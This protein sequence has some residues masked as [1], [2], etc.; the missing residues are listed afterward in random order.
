MKGKLWVLLKSL[1]KP[2]HVYTENYLKKGFNM[3]NLNKVF[4]LGNMTRDPELSYTPNGSA[5]I[6]FGIATNRK[7]KDKEGEKK[8]DVCFTEIVM[9][10]KRAE[11]ISEY[12]S[13]GSAI[14]IEG[15]LKSEQWETKDGQK[16][17]RLIVSAEN[18][19]FAGGNKKEEGGQSENMEV[20]TAEE[21]DLNMEV[22]TAE[23]K[24]LNMEEVPF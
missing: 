12:F 5:I 22:K 13:K 6:K 16:R 10:G 11:V 2:V 18:F 3:L 4:L 14:Y 15:R 23:E 19:E 8:T 9:F 1:I 24:D 7:W 20:K 17:N 21:K